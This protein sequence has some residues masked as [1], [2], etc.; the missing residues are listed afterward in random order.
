M[1]SPTGNALAYVHQVRSGSAT[2]TTEVMVVAPDGSAPQSRS[3]CVSNDQ[4]RQGPLVWS[5]DGSSLAF[6]DRYDQPVL[7]LFDTSGT[8]DTAIPWPPNAGEPY[9]IAWSPDTTQIAFLSIITG[10]RETVL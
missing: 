4:C 2:S 10:Y 3:R 9:A 6:V 7:H 1:W 5:P 8:T